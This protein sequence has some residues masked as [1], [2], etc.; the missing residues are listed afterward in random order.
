ML[1]PPTQQKEK[2]PKPIDGSGAEA[3]VLKLSE[4]QVQ[5]ILRQRA[6]KL[7]IPL[8]KEEPAHSSL[9]VLIFRLGEERYALETRFVQK[10]FR[11]AEIA[12]VP[13]T[14][15]SFLGV[16]NH[17]GQM[18]AV[19]DLSPFLGRSRRF[20][21]FGFWC[22][23]KIRWSSGFPPVRWMK[24]CRFGKPR[25]PRAPKRCLPPR[26]IGSGA[27]T[28]GP[29]RF[30]WRKEYYPIPVLSLMSRSLF[31]LLVGRSCRSLLLTLPHRPP[32]RESR[33]VGKSAC[34]RG[35]FWF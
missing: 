20:P 4:S 14:E 23:V 18:L 8:D 24:L 2:L 30:G 32:H 15:A 22:W 9:E 3:P 11:P 17:Q 33:C 27:N 26:G 6:K 34:L 29:L 25:F 12:R 35:W 5:A 19:M 16:T 7:A 10:V 28:D 21:P 1:D 13:R 31:F